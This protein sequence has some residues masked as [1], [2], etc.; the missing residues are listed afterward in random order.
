MNLKYWNCPN[1]SYHTGVPQNATCL[2]LPGIAGSL[3]RSKFARLQRWR[4]PPVCSRRQSLRRPAGCH[5]FRRSLSC[6][7][8][9]QAKHQFL[10]CCNSHSGRLRQGFSPQLR[11]WRCLVPTCL[12]NLL[13]FLISLRNPLNL[14][15]LGFRILERNCSNQHRHFLLLRHTKR[16]AQPTTALRLKSACRRMRQWFLQNMGRCSSQF[17]Q[18]P[19]R[20]CYPIQRSSNRLRWW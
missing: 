19:Q 18:N 17:L 4:K 13:E 10:P 5:R 12:R 3:A 16:M 1:Q 14:L 7:P 9:P 11:Q 6:S 20:S 15:Q 8:T 2:C